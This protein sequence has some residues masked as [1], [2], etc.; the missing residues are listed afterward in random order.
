MARHLRISSVERLESSTRP[1][2]RVSLIANHRDEN[3]S[4][5]LFDR[6]TDFSQPSRMICQDMGHFVNIRAKSRPLKAHIVTYHD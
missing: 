2:Y 4:P 1:P 6:R 3:P 5:A